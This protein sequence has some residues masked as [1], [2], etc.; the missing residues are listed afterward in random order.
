[1]HF[2][3]ALVCLSLL[4]LP[5][6]ASAADTARYTVEKLADGVHAVIYNA[7][8]DVEGNTLIVINEEDVFVVDANAGLTTAR[9]TIAEIKKLTPKPVRYLVN[10]HWHDDHVFG[11][12]AYAEAYPGVQIIAHPSTRE[13]IVNHAFANNAF[14]LDII[15]SDIARLGGYLATGIGRD[16]KPLTTEMRGRV[17]HGIRVRKEMLA[18]RGV[19][20]PVPPTVDVKDTMTLTR[21]GREIR[22]SF[23][24]R[25][26]T[27]GD[28]V[29]YLPNERI[30]ATGDLVV[31]PVPYATNVYAQDWVKT[32]D[33]LMALQSTTVLPGHGPVMR[34]WSYVRR[35]KR[36]IEQTLAGVAAAKKEGLTIAQATERVQLPELRDTFVQG[37]ETRRAGYE[38][39]FRPTLVRNAWEELDAEIMN[40]AATSTMTRVADGVYLYG[41]QRHPGRVTVLVNEKDTVLVNPSASAAAARAAVRSLRELTDKPVRYIVVTEPGAPSGAG[42][43]VFREV[44]TQADVVSATPSGTGMAVGDT[45]TLHRGE[46]EIQ[47]TRAQDGSLVVEIPKEK[48]RIARNGGVR[49]VPRPTP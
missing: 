37:V 11:N 31:A 36:T 34:D 27:R 1:M 6:L 3:R 32:L 47:I 41:S 12:Q 22:I 24:G 35:L 16:G 40:A 46:R 2:V 19:F 44:Y 42:L 8:L 43:A 23:L 29:V 25:G 30:V 49:V 26:N 13:D 7:D 10:T 18:D 5:A 15:E 33:G 20:R 38:A 14:V 4:V 28:L 45:L 39:F 21:G 9:A 17:E 48:V